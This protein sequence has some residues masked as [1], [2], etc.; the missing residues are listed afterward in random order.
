M[1]GMNDKA[2]QYGLRN[3]EHSNRDNVMSIHEQGSGNKAKKK[4]SEMTV[5]TRGA[6]LMRQTTKILKKCWTC[7]E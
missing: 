2:N 4:K 5:L 1:D 7:Q 6:V 3:R